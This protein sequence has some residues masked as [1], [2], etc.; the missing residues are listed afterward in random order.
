M[1]TVNYFDLVPIL[2]SWEKKNEFGSYTVWLRVKNLQFEVCF[3][4]IPQGWYEVQTWNPCQSGW[5]NTDFMRY[6]K[7]LQGFLRV[8]P[9]VIS[10]VCI[11]DLEKIV[12]G[13]LWSN[14]VCVIDIH[15]NFNSC[16]ITSGPVILSSP[17]ISLTVMR[18]HRGY[19][20][21]IA[22]MR[23]YQ[24]WNNCMTCIFTSVKM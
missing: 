7:N 23:H 10:N 16:F 9:T 5:R 2:Y 20:D 15:N 17:G 1:Q 6:F 13:V 24:V 21:D 18:A 14:A 12:L 4:W 3:S 22:Q 19:S 11:H 8:E